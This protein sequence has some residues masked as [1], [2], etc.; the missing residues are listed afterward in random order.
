MKL[1]TSPLYNFAMDRVNSLS[2]EDAK[3]LL[4]NAVIDKVCGIEVRLGTLLGTFVP[5]ED[6]AELP[7]TEIEMDVEEYLSSPR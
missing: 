2:G 1:T 6:L 4:K 3:Y 7:D 5:Y